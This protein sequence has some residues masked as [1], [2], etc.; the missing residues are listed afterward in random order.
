MDPSLLALAAVEIITQLKDELAKA[1][2]R[3]LKLEEQVVEKERCIQELTDGLML[4]VIK[5]RTQ[6]TASG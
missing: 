4:R 3:V 6:K 2:N 1:H 5:A